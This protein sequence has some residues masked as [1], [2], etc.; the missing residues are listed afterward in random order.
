MPQ[1]KS[2]KEELKKSL[3]RRERNLRV[4]TQIKNAIKKFRKSLEKQHLEE[5]KQILPEVY[6]VLDKAASKKV[7]H[8][9]KSARK[10]SRL[11][12]KLNK[13]LASSTKE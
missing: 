12:N 9:N 5:A 13:A 2:A 6:K 1:R 4:K 10:K 11:T 7:I 8:P 3:K